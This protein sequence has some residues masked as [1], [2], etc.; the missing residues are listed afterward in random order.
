MH[1]YIRYTRLQLH[2]R[3]FVL[4]RALAG[5]IHISSR[6]TVSI[7]T[8]TAY[9]STRVYLLNSSTCAHHLSPRREREREKAVFPDTRADPAVYSRTTR[10]CVQCVLAIYTI[11]RVARGAIAHSSMQNKASSIRAF[12]RLQIRACCSSVYSGKC[13]VINLSAFFWGLYMHLRYFVFFLGAYCWISDVIYAAKDLTIPEFTFSDNNK[14][15]I[16]YIKL[17]LIS[18]DSD[19]VKVWLRLRS[20]NLNII[21][22]LYNYWQIYIYARWITCDRARDLAIYT[23][24]SA[25]P[26]YTLC[27]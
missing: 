1:I 9:Y 12:R 16:P 5:H 22:H 2:S 14:V 6:R 20:R 19:R 18:S 26:H 4:F 13:A 3:L 21:T 8:R 23:E 7:I 17:A 11:R 27:T 10:C 25:V 15:C 24:H